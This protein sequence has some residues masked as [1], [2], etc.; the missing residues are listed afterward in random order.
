MTWLPMATPHQYREHIPWAKGSL[1]LA[2]I[3]Q[4]EG[5]YRS[6]GEIL[7]CVSTV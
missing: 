4:L 6:R 5:S 2:T 1:G 3:E 7:G